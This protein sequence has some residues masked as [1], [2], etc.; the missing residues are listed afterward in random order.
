MAPVMEAECPRKT[1]EAQALDR[2]EPEEDRAETMA[3]TSG[4][5]I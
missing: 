2:V 3:Q 5:Q 4:S 1:W